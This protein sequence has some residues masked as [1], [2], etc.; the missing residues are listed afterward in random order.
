MYLCLKKEELL[1]TTQD[2]SN[3]GKTPAYLTRN[4]EERKE[5]KTVIKQTLRAKFDGT[6]EYVI[7]GD[8]YF[9]CV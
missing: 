1:D 5:E 2:I 4:L 3:H 6:L 7:T 8:D 9:P